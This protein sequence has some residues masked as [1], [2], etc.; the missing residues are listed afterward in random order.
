MKLCLLLISIFVCYLQLNGQGAM[1]EM[2]AIR[3]T[4]S[5]VPDRKIDGL[6]TEI[7]YDQWEI[8]APFFFKKLDSWM[9]AA[10]LRY[11]CTGLDFSDA[12]LLDEDRLHSIDLA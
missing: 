2:A 3:A 7:G 4:Y 12:T 9:L 6:S 8:Q 11:Q 5:A 1:S 10:G